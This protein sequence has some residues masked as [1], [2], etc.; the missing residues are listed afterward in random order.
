M[1]VDLAAAAMFAAQHDDIQ[2]SN[3]LRMIPLIALQ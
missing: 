2:H 3:P 1:V